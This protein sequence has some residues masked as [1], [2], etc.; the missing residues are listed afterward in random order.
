MKTYLFTSLLSLL[1]LFSVAQN[2]SLDW[3]RT[4]GGSGNDHLWDM[5]TD[6]DGN[7]YSIGKF[8]DTVDFNPDS[9]AVFNLISSG[10]DDVFIQ[11][12]DSNGN[13]I[14]AK[15]F[16][17]TDD[18]IGQSIA[19]DQFGNL[20]TTGWFSGDADFDPG[21]S[22]LMLKSN[23]NSDAF[24]QK[25]D[26]QGNLIWARSFG[27]V[28]TDRSVE[29]ELDQNFNVY[30]TGYFDSLVDFNPNAGTF[31]IK[32][33]G[34][35]DMFLQK[36]DSSGN[37]IWARSTGGLEDVIGRSLFYDG[38]EHLYIAGYFEGQVDFNPNAGSTILHSDGEICALCGCYLE[39]G[40]VVYTQQGSNKVKMPNN[41]ES[42]GIPVLCSDCK[43]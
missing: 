18:D 22:T 15:S 38:G 8:A 14:W 25:I 26:S 19:A 3:V 32:S 24:V 23:G 27:G 17:G 30:T 33:K 10:G 35:K 37:F 39:P 40:E 21:T 5:T 43:D 2:A 31:N 13:F 12:L 29:I 6:P 7:I 4:S 42:L 28:E 20:Y 9:I 1:S 16:G 36:L 11:K 34:D 41:H